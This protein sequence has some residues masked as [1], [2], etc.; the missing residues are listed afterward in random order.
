MS[1][2][3]KHLYKKISDLEERVEALMDFIEENE[4]QEEFIDF[5]EK[6]RVRNKN[7][8]DEK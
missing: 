5:W 3:I 7:R 1:I 2:G 8:S 4:L 6:R